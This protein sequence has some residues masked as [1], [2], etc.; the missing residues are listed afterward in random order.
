MNFRLVLA[1]AINLFLIGSASA[2]SQADYVLKKKKLEA[3]RDA[4][5][6]IRLAKWCRGKALF[7]AER[8]AL[9]L[10]IKLN[11]EHL[12]ARKSLA[13]L[14]AQAKAH[15]R[16]ESPWRRDSRFLYVKTNTSEARLHYYC[17]AFSAFYNRFRKIFG[18]RAS[19]MKIWK[20]KIGVIVFRSQED[21]TRY[22]KE[23][24]GEMGES[25]V[26]Y[27]DPNRRELVLYEDPEKLATTLDTLFH[28]G[29]HL[30][31]D[32]ALG[33]RSENLPFW[34]S[35]GL[36]EYFGPTAY[37]R[38]K[39]SLRYGLVGT[40]LSELRELYG[41]GSAPRLAT[42]LNITEGADFESSDYAL[43]WAL[44]HMLIDKTGKDGKPRYR[45]RFIKAYQFL[46][47]GKKS[48]EVF[49][50]LF[51]DP[52]KVEKELRRYA[53]TLSRP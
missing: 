45:K 44:V 41:E 46:A 47:A 25:T 42:V 3:K 19:P 28:E 13:K 35:E 34:F 22:Q 5:G 17:Q 36:A 11:P 15:S 12:P 6:L 53:A 32:L 52:V 27:Y 10:A 14:D 4:P 24:G 48:G 39:D 43:S 23:T 16:Y 8:E 51:G 30:L 33:N 37:D 20:R 40:R 9:E 18:V 7:E 2:D 49:R 21:F 29:T 31:V 26:G 1:I 50:A 38:A